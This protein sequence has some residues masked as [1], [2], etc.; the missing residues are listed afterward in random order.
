MLITLVLSRNE[1]VQINDNGSIKKVE[2][3]SVLKY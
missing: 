1:F 3:K 2:E